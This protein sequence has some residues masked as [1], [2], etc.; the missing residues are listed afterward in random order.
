M[1]YARRGEQNEQ[2][3]V[4]QVLR[5]VLDTNIWISALIVPVGKPAQI[6]NYG[7]ALTPLI[8]EDILAEVSKV[9]RYPRIMRRYGITEDG[10]SKYLTE[11]R[12]ICTL[13][14]VTTEVRVVEDL[15]DD[16]IV[17]C[18][19]DGQ[20]D[21]IVSGDPHLLR[22]GNYQGIHIVSPSSFLA[23]LEQWAGA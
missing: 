15:R 18:A 7:E 1:Q 14:D 2:E 21:Y 17:A 11:L 10:I 5:V 4:K 12:R 9:L 22:L 16:M 20:A 23:L 8:S 13:V 19:I 6:R 3:S